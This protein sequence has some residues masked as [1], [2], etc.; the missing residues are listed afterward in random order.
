LLKQRRLAITAILL[1]AFAFERSINQQS[2][3]ASIGLLSFVL[4]SQF[5]PAIIGALYWRKANGKGALTGLIVG[6]I[7]WFFTLLLPIIAPNLAWVENGVFGLAW[8]KPTALFGVDFFR[9]NQ[10]WR[11]L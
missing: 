3:L 2:H 11:V 9:L 6:S 5:A 7:M 8:L 4:L 1:F 10:P